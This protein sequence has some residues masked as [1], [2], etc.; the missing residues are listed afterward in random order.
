MNIVVLNG[1]ELR[2]CTYHLKESFLKP[3]RP[4]HAI[5]EFYFPTDLP[6]FCTG[7]KTCFTV[8]EDRCPHAAYVAPI[9]AAMREADL[10]VFAY[11]VYAGHVPAQLKAVLDH[12]CSHW[13]VHR[14]EAAM[15]TKR[16][17]VLTN[18]IG[19][20]NR[21]AQKDVTDSLQWLGI[22]DIRTLGLKFMGEVRW[23]AVSDK[24]KRRMLR[25]TTALANTY[26][27]PKRGAIGWRVR[28][29]YA[30]ARMMQRGL[31]KKGVDSADVQHWAANRWFK[32]LKSDGGVTR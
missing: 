25:K 9:W 3:L 21:P 11:P 5:R 30:L 2:G 8:S 28:A 14:P 1:T 29:Y 18:S 22:T 16:A 4:H 17:V 10:L 15:C 7:C 31:Y 19:I 6:H 23:H 26:L 27:M 13:I 12:I 24:R 20:P 32:D